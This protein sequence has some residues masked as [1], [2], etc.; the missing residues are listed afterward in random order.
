MG[1]LAALAV[2]TTTVPAECQQA[3][4][5]FVDRVRLITCEPAASVPCF[6]LQ[7][8]LLDEKGAPLPA[9]LPS[10][11]MLRDLLTVRINGVDIAPFYAVAA[12]EEMKAQARSRL[13]LLLMDVSGSMNEMLP[14][15]VSRFSG[16]RTA[17][18]E[19]LKNFREETDR[20]AIAPFGSHDV[21]ATIRSVP[22]VKTVQEAMRQIESLPPPVSANNTA[23]YSAVE[24]GIQV[25]NEQARGFAGSPEVILL[26]LTDGKNYVGSGDDPGL[27]SGPP[28][29]QEVVKRVSTS[30]VQVVAIG[31]GESSS[32][33]EQ[34]LRQMSA[35]FYLAR[36][37]EALK[38]AFAVA[39]ADP[40]YSI[41]RIHCSFASPWEDRTFLAGRMLHVQLWMRLPSGQALASDTALWVAPHLSVPLY[42]GHGDTAEM[43]ALLDARK[44]LPPDEGWII[45]IRPILIFAAG[46]LLI[47][48]L[49]LWIPRLIWAE[50]YTGDLRAIHGGGRWENDP[51]RARREGGP[52]AGR[53]GPPGFERGGG[54]RPPMKRDPGDATILGGGDTTH[55]DD[56]R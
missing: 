47:M 39:R 19:F 25:L 6:R 26:V 16:A 55:V 50:Q 10:G 21:I 15:G 7:A 54:A 17:A 5:K 44:N 52:P 33:D 45:L 43:K 49:W 2:V 56:D 51:K 8:D 42:D 3:R 24:V 9:P 30:G 53:P 27:L 35:R 34:A 41:N 18:A 36:D 29:L 14:T 46:A 4:L 28:G 31:L 23:L 40:A 48:I 1:V 22:F 13:A 12:G 32:I 38:Q 11:Q 20:V 37:L